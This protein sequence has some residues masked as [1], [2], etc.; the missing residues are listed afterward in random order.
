MQWWDIKNPKKQIRLNYNR[1]VVNKFFKNLE[2]RGGVVGCKAILFV[3]NKQSPELS[4]IISE[5]L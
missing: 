1:R 3:Y 5:K 2:T 4:Y